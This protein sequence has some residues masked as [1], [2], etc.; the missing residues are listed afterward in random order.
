MRVSTSEIKTPF[1]EVVPAENIYSERDQSYR[2]KKEFWTISGLLATSLGQATSGFVINGNVVGACSWEGHSLSVQRNALLSGAGV[3]ECS[4]MTYL[5]ISGPDASS[6][7]DYLGPRSIS[8]MRPGQV[9]F[10]IFT[11][12]TGNIDDEA[13]LLCLA[14]DRYLL[15]LGGCKIPSYIDGGS[16]KF[17]ELSIEESSYISFNIKGPRRLDA[18][19][20]LLLDSEH[21]KVAELRTFTF[22]HSFTREHHPVFVV[23]TKI[24]IEMWAEPA[25]ITWA[26]REMLSNRNTYTPC[27]WDVLHA[28]RM[29]CTEIFFA[30]FPLD[31]NPQTSLLDIG[32]DWMLR[33][34]DS[35]FVGRGSL[36]SSGYRLLKLRQ[37][38]GAII[39]P[40]ANTI[41]LNAAGEKVGYITSSAVPLRSRYPMAFAFVNS[42]NK[43]D[44][45]SISGAKD[46]QWFVDGDQPV[47]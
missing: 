2:R 36:K 17:S 35:D 8:Q 38:S 24:G 12:P 21:K 47:G 4:A 20:A 46:S 13:L 5:E 7:L 26:W 11:T 23:K 44:Y 28:F 15:S 3:F 27:G 19:K 14:K 16:S 40:S 39:P 31:I 25:P 34:K 33:E 6:L 30:L 41:L 1:T 9:K 45:F 43:I 22:C 18:I 32:C 42:T 10:V 29:D 37:A